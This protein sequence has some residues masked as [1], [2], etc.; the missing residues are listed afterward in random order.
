MS[1]LSEGKS[2][3]TP[4]IITEED[5]QDS[6]DV[7]DVEY[8][9]GSVASPTAPTPA[10]PRVRTMG[11]SSRADRSTVTPSRSGFLPSR[12]NLSYLSPLPPS[13]DGSPFLRPKGRSLGNDRGSILT[14]EQLA[15]HNQSIGD[16]D[17]NYLLSEVPAPF[18]SGAVSPILDVPESPS[19]SALPSPTGYGSIS[20]VLLPEVTP[21]PAIH[22]TALLFESGPSDFADAAS[23]TLLR[24]QLAAAENKAQE[25]LTLIEELENQLR[26]A[27]EARMRDAQELSAQVAELEQKMHENRRNDEQR[28]NVICSLEDEVR[29]MQVVREQAVQKAITRTQEASRISL[30]AALRAQ[31]DKWEVSCVAKSTCS[32]WLTVRETAEAELEL[33]RSS[34][35]TLA[36]LLSSLTQCQLQL[37]C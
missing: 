1:V 4:V 6:I 35:D 28:L 10:I 18:R 23:S 25:R 15:Q 36:L 26:T 3:A 9:L 29:Q 30:E 7:D 13:A 14:W 16:E 20:Q 12:S 27:K 5:S 32:A 37:S 8:L 21:S 17:M 33:V 22:N 24:L 34:R 11:M 2:P 31:Q 19:L